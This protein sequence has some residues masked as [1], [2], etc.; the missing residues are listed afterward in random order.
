MALDI[1]A[2]AA[3]ILQ[4]GHAMVGIDDRLLRNYFP[5]YDHLLM[6]RGMGL[7]VAMLPPF[8]SINKNDI[9][10]AGI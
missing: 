9:C 6:L 3:Y 7:Y 2:I 10:V 1:A 5:G 8:H 4:D